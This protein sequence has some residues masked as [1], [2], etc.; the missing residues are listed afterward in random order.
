MIGHGVLVYSVFSFKDNT[1]FAF[2]AFGSSFFGTYE[3]Y[4]PSINLLVFS[5]FNCFGVRATRDKY[6]SSW[7]GSGIIRRNCYIR[8][9]YERFRDRINSTELDF[10]SLS[11]TGG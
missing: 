5:S 7:E 4:P 3:A 8:I 6:S 9:E 10:S 11:N 1:I 2:F